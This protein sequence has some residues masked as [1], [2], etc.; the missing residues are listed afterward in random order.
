[1]LAMAWLRRVAERQGATYVVA[2]SKALHQS[3]GYDKE[4][5]PTYRPD[6][7]KRS[8]TARSEPYK[9]NVLVMRYHIVC[10]FMVI[11]HTT[12]SFLQDHQ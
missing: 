8:L 7:A 2:L 12:C 11:I 5:G 4:C 3:L 10:Y 9:L 1:M 6:E